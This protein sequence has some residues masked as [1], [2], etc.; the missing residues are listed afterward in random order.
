[1]SYWRPNTINACGL[2][3]TI[4][5]DKK[6]ENLGEYFN[7][8]QFSNTVIMICICIKRGREGPFTIE[9]YYLNPKNACSVHLVDN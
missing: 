5:I 3:H 1:M 7:N 9:N 8:L 2:T 4:S 6:L